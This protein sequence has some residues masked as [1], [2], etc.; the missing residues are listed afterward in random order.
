M[1]QMDGTEATGHDQ[2][3]T[4]Q[5]SLDLDALAVSDRFRLF[6]FTRRDDHLAYLWV[7]RALERLRAV[8]HVQAHPEDVA[9]ALAELATAHEDVP[10]EFDDPTALRGRLDA[11]ASDQIL[12]RLEDAARAGSLA[13]YRNRQSVY[14]FSELGYRAYTAVEDVL[15]A[16]VRDANLSRLVFSDIL[17]DLRALHAAVRDA[18]GDQVYRRLSRL[19]T[20][21]DDMSRR[22]AQFHLTLGEIMRSTDTSPETFMKYKN[23]LLTHMTDF[24]AEL[25]RYLP[26][27]AAAIAAIDAASASA[28]SAGP[29][30]E[31]A[32]LALAAA[33]DDRPFLSAADKRDDWRRRWAALRAWFADDPHREHAGESRAEGL[34]TATRAA[35]SGVIALLRQVT[36]AQR[37]GVNRSSQLRHLAEWVFAAPDEPAAHALMTAAFNLRTARHLGGAH[38]DADQVSSRAT[39]WDAPGVDISVTLFKRGKAPTPGVP[40]P[41][42]NNP[43]VKAALARRQ[44][45]QRAAE[46]AAARSLLA[47]GAHDRVLDENET[48]VLLRLLTLATEARTIVAGRLATATG[49]NDVL[50]MRLVPSDRG[51]TVAT[52][53]GTLHLPGFELELT[54]STQTPST[55]GPRG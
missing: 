9:Q 26:R 1:E 46:R 23:A 15:R 53:H 42:R 11:L 24:M 54:P 22:A 16:R 51:S 48:R 17:E 27:L 44:A 8:H 7:L 29:G 25:D 21:L 33:A 36:E 45:E 20:V 52:L 6:N 39:W 47:D 55:P 35:V 28:A 10:G 41:A 34:R 40:Q 38:D 32:L 13:R 50:T 49:G 18:D 19:D 31:D 14:Q 4:A 3:G 12:H 30:G 2:P 43:A 5:A 37:G